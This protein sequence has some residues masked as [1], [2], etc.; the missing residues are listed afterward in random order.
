MNKNLKSLLAIVT[1]II[2]AACTNQEQ[3][4]QKLITKIE[5]DVKPLRK[6]ACIAQWDGSISGKSEDFDR[7]A[8]L[9]QQMTEYY[10]NK[11]ILNQL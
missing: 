1:V 7:Y 3:E 4:L 6:E 5:N 2:M 11:E 10:S 8:Q 9:S